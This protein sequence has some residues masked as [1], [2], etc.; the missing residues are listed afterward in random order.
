MKDVG[1][2]FDELWQ[3][4]SV[5]SGAQ[6]KALVLTRWNKHKESSLTNTVLMT[7]EEANTHDKLDDQVDLVGYYGSGICYFQSTEL[8][9]GTHFLFL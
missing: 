6:D 9:H 3:G 7:K 5:V 4:K 8:D 1:Y 2:I